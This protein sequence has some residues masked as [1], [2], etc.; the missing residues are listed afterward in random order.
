[1]FFDLIHEHS[2][3]LP[4]RGIYGYYMTCYE[5]GKHR[6]VKIDFDNQ[7]VKDTNKKSKDKKS[8]AKMKL[9]A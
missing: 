1:M 6:K 5:C 2:W 4:L 7:F 9:A 8:Q 3:G